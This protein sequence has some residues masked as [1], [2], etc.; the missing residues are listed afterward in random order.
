M[1]G[2]RLV[3][4]IAS[5]LLL[6]AAVGIVAAEQNRLAMQFDG[7]GPVV[8]FES[9]QGEARGN[10]REVV[11]ALAPCFTVVTYDRYGIGESP[12]LKDPAA[13]VL[14]AEVA[15]T[16]LA[17][18]HAHGLAEPYILVGHSLGGLYVQAFARRH[19]D[20]VGGLV[21]VDASSPLEP[22]GVFVSTMPPKPGT[23]EASEEAGVTP[24][25]AAL[26]SGPQLPPVPL[27]VIAAT[28]HDDT[29]ER[30]DLWQQIQEDT[31]ALSPNGRLV[32]AES[33]HYVQKE[34]PD[35]VADAV[36]D[37][38]AEIGIEAGVCRP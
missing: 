16:L 3:T 14:A 10:W 32:V 31:A 35:I 2:R 27:V 13:P 22:E 37:I 30:E 5:A 23:V 1:R 17:A 11:E 38:A 34:R 18:L 21:L 25:M 33:G 4:T 20:A 8:V 9:G 28:D 6:F 19:P 36:V 26:R 7:K 29:K 24:S 15:E 12:P